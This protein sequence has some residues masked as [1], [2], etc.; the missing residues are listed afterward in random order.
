MAVSIPLG[1][2]SAKY[3]GGWLDRALTVINQVVMAVPPFFT[4]ILFTYLF[5]LVLH[6]FIAGAFPAAAW[7]IISV[8]SSSPRSPSR[9]R[10][11]P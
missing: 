7:G 1:V 5:G 8:I 10:V 6:L 3:A 4:G 9:C 11:S 2:L